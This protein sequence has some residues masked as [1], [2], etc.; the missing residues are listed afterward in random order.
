MAL[1]GGQVAR[2]ALSILEDYPVDPIVIDK[3]NSSHRGH[4]TISVSLRNILA[5]LEICLFAT[6][7]SMMLETDI[8]LLFL[9]LEM[10]ELE[11]WRNSNTYA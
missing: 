6:Y 7:S 9:V 4:T 2:F 3:V 11:G 1:P 8:S 10:R 5:F